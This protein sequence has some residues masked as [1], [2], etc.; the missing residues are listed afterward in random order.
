[1]SRPDP[2]EIVRRGYDLVSEAYRSDDFDWADSSYAAWLPKLIKRLSP[3]TEVLDLG[4]GC[5]I[6][7]T[8]ILS[9]SFRVT[10]VD[11]SSVQ[12]ERARRLVP[13]SHFILGD[14]VTLDFDRARFD[15][16]VAFYAIIHVPLEHQQQL[17]ARIWS[18]I[19]PG[20]LFLAVV[21]NES[22][23]GTEE[24]WCGVEDATMYWSHADARTYRQWFQ[25]AGFDLVEEGFIPE[26]DGGH[27]IILAERSG[28]VVPVRRAR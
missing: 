8:R 9:E 10:G 11:C 28:G 24:N 16:V 17:L 4:C 25:D 15:A 5:G 2:E 1:M 18:W 6:P 22:W 14:M 21:G 23:T 19:R 7:V 3:G 12:I 26:G 20:G 27:S 13:G